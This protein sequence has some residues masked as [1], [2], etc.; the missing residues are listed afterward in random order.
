[1]ESLGGKWQLVSNSASKRICQFHSSKPQGQ[2]F[3]FD[4]MVFSKC[5]IGWAKNCGMS[6]MLWHWKAMESLGGKWLQ[7][8]YS[9]Q[10]KIC[11]FCSSK[12]QGRNLKFHGVLFPKRYIGWAKNFGRSFILWHWRVMA[13]L[14]EN[15]QLV[16]DWAQKKICQFRSSKPQRQNFKFDGMV[17]S[18]RYIGW[19]KN[20]GTSFLSWHWKIV[21]SFSQIWIV[22]SNSAYQKTVKFLRAS[23]KAKISNFISWFSLK[24]NLPENKI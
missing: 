6:F 17:F 11:E 8:S 5:Y 3:K 7:V 10:E 12:P 4:G 21:E 14:G 13:S 20:C 15:W 19:A 16:S 24:G 23:K 2:N 22:V 9:A 1:M 18:K